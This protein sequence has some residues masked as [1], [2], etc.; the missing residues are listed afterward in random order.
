MKTL[1]FV[2]TLLLGTIL[3]IPLSSSAITLTEV[4]GD[5]DAPTDIVNA[6]DGSGRL[7]FVEKE[8]LVKIFKNGEVSPQSFLDIQTLVSTQSER[9][10]LSMA[11]HPKY[12]SNRK[13]YVYYTDRN[14]DITIAQ[15]R[16][17]LSNKDR[18]DSASG[19][20]ILRIRHREH[21]NHNGGQ[22][23]FGPDGF[24]YIGVGDG[25]G[26]GDPLGNA[27]NRR[28]L[29]GKILRIDI[30]R[31]S[32]YS[33]PSDN[34]Y[35][36]NSRARPEIF[37][38]GF[39]NPWRITFD[40]STK[41]LFVADVGQSEREEIDIVSRGRNYGWNTMEGSLCYPNPGCSQR[42]LALPIF[43]YAHDGN[44]GESITGGYVYRGRRVPALVGKY[45]Y[46]DFIS[47]RIWALSR[48]GR[49][50]WSAELL[51]DTAMGVS[52]FGV[53]EKRDLFVADYGAGKI[54]RF[55]P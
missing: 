17:L 13:F 54:Y 15:Y 9:G 4:A 43:D 34:P 53:D 1:L 20:L 12:R 29:L 39:R 52:T 6:G 36:G 7:F 24:L 33:I 37:A 41:R 47:G 51:T 38:Y 42:G 27:Q 50:P 32:R 35:R 44:G 46:G 22:L 23:R 49:N 21:D 5:L 30:D 26:G 11:F 55:D 28:T 31:G 3:F 25:G 48:E 45:I 19:R 40:V 8:G 10:L 16:A 14:G 2:T 18:A